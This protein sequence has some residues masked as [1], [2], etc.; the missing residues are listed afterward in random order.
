MIEEILITA[1]HNDNVDPFLSIWT[2]EI[3]VYLFLGGMTAG[4]MTALPSHCRVSGP[5]AVTMPLIS[6]PRVRGG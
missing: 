1:R 3:S 2:W 4:M 6:W 5:A